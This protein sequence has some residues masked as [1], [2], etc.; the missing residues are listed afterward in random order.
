M[1]EENYNNGNYPNRNN[2]T[3][4]TT[5][6]ILITLGVL[7]LVSKYFPQ[8]N[9]ADIWPFLLIVVGI[10]IIYRGKKK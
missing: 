4:L 2:D 7:F 1:T 8:I 3:S 9:F 6:I 10:L 5:G